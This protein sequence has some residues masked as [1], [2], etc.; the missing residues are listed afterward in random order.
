MIDAD[1]NI[2]MWMKVTGNGIAINNFMKIFGDVIE[3]NAR[4]ASH[5]SVEPTYSQFW[6]RK[7]W[8]FRSLSPL[9]V[10]F[11]DRNNFSETVLPYQW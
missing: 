9:P 11:S 8:V 1:A 3:F 5:L 10:R 2:L 4:T 6:P 7:N